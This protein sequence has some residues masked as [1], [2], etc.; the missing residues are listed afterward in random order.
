MTLTD[1]EQKVWEFVQDR[2]KDQVRKYTGE[3]YTN[4]LWEVAEIVYPYIE[5]D[6]MVPVALMHDILEDT[7]TSTGDILVMLKD[8]GY[9]YETSKDIIKGVLALTDVYTSEA[10]PDLN[11]KGRKE[12]ECERLSLIK[13]KWQ[14]IKYCDI[15]SNTS[16][17]TR[18]DRDFAKIYLDEKE[19]ILDKMDSGNKK[20]WYLAKSYIFGGKADLLNIKYIR[21]NP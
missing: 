5:D 16:T 9:D 6:T 19:N 4:H 14:S 20:L 8:A 1:R 11:R 2:H 18:Y 21:T 3:P 15:V 10:R 7:D 13:S 17:I 12:L